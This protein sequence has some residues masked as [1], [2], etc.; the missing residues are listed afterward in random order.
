MLVRTQYAKS[1]SARYYISL[2][3][4]FEEYEDQEPST[5]CLYE[6]G[7]HYGGPEEGGWYYEYGL[8]L[9]TICVFS[10]RQAIREALALE[11]YAKAEIGKEKDQLGWPTY[12]VC[13]DNKYAKAY[14]EVR[15]HYE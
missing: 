11:A 3:N 1:K 9:R 6:C 13:Y 14:P 7:M 12:R 4:L 2:Y 5:V 8:P 15:P 10:R